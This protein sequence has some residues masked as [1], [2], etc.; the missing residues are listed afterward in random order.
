MRTE[1]HYRYAFGSM[2][3]ITNAD[4]ENMLS[5][6]DISD[7]D[8]SHNSSALSLPEFTGVFQEREYATEGYDED[9]FSLDMLKDNIGFVIG[10]I[11]HFNERETIYPDLI[12]VIYNSKDGWTPAII[13]LLLGENT[14]RVAIIDNNSLPNFYKKD[15]SAVLSNMWRDIIGSYRKDKK[16]AGKFTKKWGG[17][18]DNLSNH[19][20]TYGLTKNE[21]SSLRVLRDL[22]E[23]DQ[24]KKSIR[25]NY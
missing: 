8:F 25:K 19:L 24:K 10:N 18:I 14:S 17:L 11:R 21:Y 2:E 13:R 3:Q 5:T 4:F 6:E 22:Q 16:E 7:L 12:S 9:F 15:T 1:D 20:S 23:A